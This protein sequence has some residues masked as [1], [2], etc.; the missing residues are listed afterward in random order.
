MVQYRLPIA[1]NRPFNT[2]YG[3][4]PAR[5]YLRLYPGVF[6][7]PEWIGVPD[8]ILREWAT[9]IPQQGQ[10]VELGGTI[11]QLVQNILLPTGQEFSTVVTIDDVDAD[12]EIWL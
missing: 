11:Y 1:I 9:L 12:Y 5:L 7:P 4:N 6:V 2:P 10:T 8:G 3:I